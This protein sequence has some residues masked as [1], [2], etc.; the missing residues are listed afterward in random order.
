MEAGIP[1]GTLVCG[2]GTTADV[3]GSARSPAQLARFAFLWKTFNGSFHHMTASP[4]ITLWR[5]SDYTP[6]PGWFRSYSIKMGRTQVWL[7]P[8]DIDTWSK[9]FRLVPQIVTENVIFC[10]IKPCYPD[11]VLAMYLTARC[12]I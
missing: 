2:R 12:Y 1:A 11:N 4:F 10:I 7:M 3:E 9:N 6:T 5:M 8:C